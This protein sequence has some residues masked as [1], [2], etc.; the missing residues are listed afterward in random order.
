[1]NNFD[2]TLK[3]YEKLCKAIAD[4]KYCNLTFEKYFKNGDKQNEHYLILRHDVDEDCKYALDLAIVERQFN[5][6][7]TYYFRMKKQ[8]YKPEIIDKIVSMNHE[9]GYHYETVDKCRGDVNA[10]I[11][12]FSDE[13]SNFRQRYNINTAC[14]HGNVLTEYDN[15]SIW[16][17]EKLSTF[18]LIGEPYISLDYSKFVYFSDSGRTWNNNNWKKFKDKINVAASFYPRNTNDLI[19]IVE[20]GEPDNICI[21]AHPERWSR[22]TYDYGK[23]YFIDFM[24]LMGKAMIYKL[25]R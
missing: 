23:R 24:Y 19:K 20:N 3:K 1:M 11:A 13:I 8:T 25:R 22:N 16:L 18:N 6:K 10:A 4:S 9:I 15:K 12:M 5:L 2:F 21:L 14:M 17:H 7:S